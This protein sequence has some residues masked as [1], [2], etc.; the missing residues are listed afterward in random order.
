MKEYARHAP[1][2]LH[3]AA[4]FVAELIEPQGDYFSDEN[5]STMPQ[6]IFTLG[7]EAVDRETTAQMKEI[8]QL[9]EKYGV[10]I[11]DIVADNGINVNDD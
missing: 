2:C 9:C 5:Q 11:S 6:K 1:Y 4:Y 10:S 7:G 8:Y 3:S